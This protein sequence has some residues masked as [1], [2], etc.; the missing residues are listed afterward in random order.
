[1]SMRTSALVE[2][3]ET[4]TIGADRAAQLER[5]LRTL[6]AAT[7]GSWVTWHVWS[8]APD[9]TMRCILPQ[10]AACAAEREAEEA[11]KSGAPGHGGAPRAAGTIQTN[12]VPDAIRA[13]VAEIRAALE[14]NAEGLRLP[15]S[16][17][18]LERWAKMAED[19]LAGREAA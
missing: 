9:G 4:R 12:H 19:A 2:H 13:L 14:P 10:C 5:A 15:P 16:P 8:T 3:G 6:L 7:R 11:L 1:M 17:E 18:T